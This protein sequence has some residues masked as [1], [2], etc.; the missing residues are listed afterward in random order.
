MSFG[1]S[2]GDAIVLTQLAARAVQNSRKAC[3][4]HDELTHDLTSLQIV[5]GRLKDEAAKSESPINQSDDS[6]QEELKSLVVGSEKIL[7]ILENILHR[8][9]SLSQEERSSRKLWQRI[10][11]GNGEMQNL[12]ELRARLT[13]YTSALSLFL[14]M[15]SVGSMGRV[16]KRMKEAGGDLREIRLAVNG[17]TAQLLASKDR[18]GSVR[19]LW[20]IFSLCGVCLNRQWTYHS[21]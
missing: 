11:F 2:I 14:N 16:E 18:E 13:Y 3:G 19:E 12:A 9:N 6:C 17:I 1:F 4:A 20:S 7:K 10:R 21:L 5:L 8:Y 15:V